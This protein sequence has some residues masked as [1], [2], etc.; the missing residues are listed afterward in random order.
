MTIKERGIEIAH[1]A[2]G[3]EEGC[4]LD[5]DPP[6]KVCIQVARRWC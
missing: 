2:N 5:A 6:A 4:I 1:F 3:E